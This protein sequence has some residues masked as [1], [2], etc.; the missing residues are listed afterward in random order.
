MRMLPL[1]QAQAQLASLVDEIVRSRGL[2]AIARNGE[3]AVVMLSAEDYEAL[4]ET[5][6]LLNDSSA[7]IRID[8]ARRDIAAGNYATV[9]ELAE[10]MAER[11]E[12]DG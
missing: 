11:R 1:A 7:R 8:Q 4:Q 6:A 2:V 10:I 9:E 5:L 12:S 3:P